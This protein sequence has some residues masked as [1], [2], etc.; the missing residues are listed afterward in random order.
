[1]TVAGATQTLFLPLGTFLSCLLLFLPPV[2]SSKLTP[3]DDPFAMMQLV[4]Q[5]QW[6]LK[7]VWC[8]HSGGCR[9]KLHRNVLETAEKRRGFNTVSCNS[10]NDVGDWKSD[11]KREERDGKNKGKPVRKKDAR[12]VRYYRRGDE[13]RE[14]RVEEDHRPAARTPTIKDPNPSRVLAVV[15]Y[16][17]QAPSH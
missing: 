17:P 8:R 1:M 6:G 13:E 14:M 16:S 15:D 3:N 2:E 7:R 11:G 10:L 12:A 4:F 5:A 9:S